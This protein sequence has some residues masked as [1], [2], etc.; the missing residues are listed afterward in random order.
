MKELTWRDVKGLSCESDGCEHTIV[1]S[2]LSLCKHCG[3][4]ACEAC[5]LSIEHVLCAIGHESE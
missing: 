1:N 5:A 2:P 4:W 3:Q